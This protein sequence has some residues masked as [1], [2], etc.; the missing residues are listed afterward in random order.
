M[1]TNLIPAEMLQLLD[2]VHTEFPELAEK[3]SAN[4]K[5]WIDI[6]AITAAECDIVLDGYYSVDSINTLIGGLHGRLKQ[7]SL[8]IVS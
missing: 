2:L 8:I 1:Q 7:S 3:I 4:A 5:D 6:L